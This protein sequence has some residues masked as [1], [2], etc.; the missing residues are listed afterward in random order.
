MNRKKFIQQTVLGA[1]S[2]I[3]VL[4]FTNGQHKQ[5][6][7]D[8][9]PQEKVKEFVIAGHGNFDQLKKLLTES[10]TLLY[11]TCICYLGLGKW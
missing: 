5:P 3:A 2:V 8:S 1:G 11:A 7:G 6:E 10:P 4:V 9:L